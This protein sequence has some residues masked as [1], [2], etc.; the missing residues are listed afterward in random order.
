MPPENGN[1]TMNAQALMR[2]HMQRV[3]A[4]DFGL[5]HDPTFRYRLKK[6]FDTQTMQTAGTTVEFFST[7]TSTK[8]ANTYG[9]AGCSL[10]ESGQIDDRTDFLLLGLGVEVIAQQGGDDADHADMAILYETGFLRRLWFGNNVVLDGPYPFSELGL[11]HGITAA[12]VD[13]G[14]AAGFEADSFAFGQP[15]LGGI[16]LA[17][18][19]FARAYGRGGQELSAECGIG[20][21]GGTSLTAPQTVRLVLTGIEVTPRA[22]GN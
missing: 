20:K 7:T 5:A 14:A 15:G 16:G 11:N 22:S 9:E 18:P 4:E 17:L 8:A 2:A 1:G 13:G 12:A 6:H 10:R 21:S 19:T 3:L